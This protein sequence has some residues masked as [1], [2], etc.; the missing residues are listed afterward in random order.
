MNL[1][2]LS[3]VR[4]TTIDVSTLLIKEGRDSC[5]RLEEKE[6]RRIRVVKDRTEDRQIFIFYAPLTLKQFMV[7]VSVYRTLVK[8]RNSK[9]QKKAI[10][11]KE[12]S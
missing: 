3:Y 12:R 6:R 1:P 10:D 8:K 9:D 7:A 5:A 2:P 4:M 11:R